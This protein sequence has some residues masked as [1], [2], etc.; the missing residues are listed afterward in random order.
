M[1]DQNGARQLAEKLPRQIL[2]VHSIPENERL[3]LTAD[4]AIRRYVRAVVDRGV[5]IIVLHPFMSVPIDQNT[6]AY[7]LSLAHSLSTQLRAN[8]FSPAVISSRSLSQGDGPLPGWG[9]G[10]IGWGIWALCVALIGSVCE[11]SRKTLFAAGIVFAG[12]QAVGLGVW[13]Q[14]WMGLMGFLWVCL[15]PFLAVVGGHWWLRRST[16]LWPRWK[17]WLGYWAL[18][19]GVL[20]VGVIV[21]VAIFSDVGYLSGALSFRG[22]KLSLMISLGGIAGF[23]W[24]EP[25]RM[26]SFIYVFKRWMT[27]PLRMWVV[28]VGAM[29]AGV[30]ALYL[31]RSGNVTQISGVE[32]QGREW[33]EGL[34]GIRPRTKELVLAYPVLTVTLWMWHDPKCRRIR[35]WGMM[36]GSLAFVSTM[37]TFCHFYSP[38]W[39]ACSRTF[40]A[41]L[42]GTL[43]GVIVIG[44]IQ[45]IR[46]WMHRQE[47]R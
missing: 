45:G 31:I 15:I 36:I 16:V 23:L 9:F 17:L 40:L 12:C 24:L 27:R 11:L 19:G 18:V 4:K 26:Q 47:S 44:G 7:N 35:K 22:I 33:L 1:V 37:N 8:G 29:I 42:G 32:T 30:I 14:A 28:P 21:L 10:L 25:H 20:G 13:A 46:K 6:A 34:V 5:K 43:L 41:F 2:R 39:V 3:K 38:L